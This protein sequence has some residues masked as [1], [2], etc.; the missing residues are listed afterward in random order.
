MHKSAAADWG[1]LV[2][3]E[4]P[5]AHGIGLS[6]PMTI[7]LD[8]SPSHGLFAEPRFVLAEAM[9]AALILMHHALH[10]GVSGSMC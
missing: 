2:R 9:R 7:A 8:R 5:W 10:L 1:H 4:R 6:G 3:Y